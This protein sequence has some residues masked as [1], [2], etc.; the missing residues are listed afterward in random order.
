M[1]TQEEVLFKKVYCEMVK[2]VCFYH[3]KEHLLGNGQ[4]RKT[5]RNVAKIMAKHLNEQQGNP[6]GWVDENI[7]IRKPVVYPEVEA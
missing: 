6:P 2:F 4:A 5:Y 1:S 3:G 7:R